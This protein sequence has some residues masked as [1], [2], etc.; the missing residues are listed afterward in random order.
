[1]RAERVGRWL[2]AIGLALSAVPATASAAVTITSGPSG[3][4][5]RA[6]GTRAT[7]EWVSSDPTATFYCALDEGPWEPCTSPKTYDGMEY[8]SHQLRVSSFGYNDA[9]RYWSPPIET[10]FVSTPPISTQSATATFVF[11]SDAKDLICNADFDAE[12][13][14]CTSP[15]TATF[16]EG[17]HRFM[18]APANHSGD[19]VTRY[20]SVDN[21]PPNITVAWSQPQTAYGWGIFFSTDDSIG[22][23]RCALDGGP[24]VECDRLQSFEIASIGYGTHTITYVATDMAGNVGPEGSYTWT[25]PDPAAP[26]PASVKPAP[27]P[28]PRPTFSD[29]TRELF[30]GVSAA[31]TAKPGRELAR[32]STLRTS[33][34]APRAG[35]LKLSLTRAGSLLA[36]GSKRFAHS[37]RAEV[38]MRLTKAGR[39]LLKRQRRQRLKLDATY[40]VAGKPFASATHVVM[41]RHG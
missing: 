12:W 27:T 3:S 33:F 8:R 13:T 20:W 16:A 10:R 37:G 32:H 18:V 30:A 39:A 4:A 38:S 35:T 14:P 28:A 7:F 1:M 11:G 22:S 5:T 41:T 19:P 34:V 31:L 2:I 9:T 17:E 40:L 6:E 21:T 23:F 15:Y 25:I 36:H 24:I 26:P 29:G